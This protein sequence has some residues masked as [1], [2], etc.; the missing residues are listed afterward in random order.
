[1]KQKILVEFNA[2]RCQVV[3]REVRPLREKGHLAVLQ[4]HDNLLQFIWRDRA[5]NQ[6]VWVCTYIN[7]YYFYLFV[8]FKI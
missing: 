6:I 3:S 1:M 7:I 8:I 4:I 2:G 5:T